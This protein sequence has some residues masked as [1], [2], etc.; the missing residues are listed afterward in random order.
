MASQ[1]VIID[2]PLPEALS[3][4]QLKA[5]GLGYIEALA[6]H[7]WSNLNTSDPGV[8]IL[9]QLCYAQTELG[10][11]AQFPIADV[12]TQADGK[13]AYHNQ[14]F[15]PQKILTSGP[16]TLGDYRKLAIDS[17]KAVNNL[18]LELEQEP[19]SKSEP[20]CNYQLTGGY[21]AFVYLANN[22]SSTAQARLLAD[23]QARLNQERNLAEVFRLPQ[24]LQPKE[25]YIHGCV[26]LTPNAQASQVYQSLIQ[27]LNQYVSPYTQQSGFQ[28]LRSAGLT[29]SEIFNGPEL[30]CGWMASGSRAIQEAKSHG[31]GEKRDWVRLSELTSLI[32]ACEGV[33][34][35]DALSIKS[36]TS[37]NKDGLQAREDIQIHAKYVANLQLAKDFKLVQDMQTQVIVRQDSSSYFADTQARHQAC[38]IQAEVDLY[39]KLPSGE[40]RDISDYYSVQNTMP[41]VYAIGANALDANASAY[42]IAQSRQLKGYLTLYDQLLA[43]QFSQLA[44]IGDLFSFTGQYNEGASWPLKSPH[45][46]YQRFTTTYYFQPLYQVPDIKPLLKGHLSYHYQFDGD[47]TQEQLEAKAWKQYRVDPFNQYIYG[48]RQAMESDRNALQR[49]NQMLNH[50]MARHGD[51]A[52]LYEDMIKTCQWFGSELKTLVMVKS[53]WLQNYQSLS[54]YRNRAYNFSEAN[55]LSLPGRYRL[56]QEHFNKL[57]ELMPD[58]ELLIHVKHLIGLANDNKS[59][60]FIAMARYLTRYASKEE[61]SHLLKRI[62]KLYQEAAHPEDARYLHLDSYFCL[63][64]RLLT[65][66]YLASNDGVLDQ[67]QIF[68]QAKLHSAD[69]DNFSAFEL[70]LNLLL[71]FAQRLMILASKLKELL[72][73]DS[74]VEW[75]VSGPKT[76]E[77][78]FFSESELMIVRGDGESLADRVHA[79]GELLLE[80]SGAKGKGATVR[81]YHK[82]VSQL[83]WLAEQRKGCILIEHMLL[84]YQDEKPA[85]TTSHGAPLI[86]DDF[87]FLQASMLFP[88]YVTLAQQAYFKH[89]LAS[90]VGLH[91]PAHI[92]LN[93]FTPSFDELSDFIAQFVVMHN[94]LA[95]EPGPNSSLAAHKIAASLF[96]WQKKSH[97]V[98]TQS[99]LV[100]DG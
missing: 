85:S 89:Y 17:F 3:Y 93:I 31:P 88:G 96:Q 5:K 64:E 87:Y 68:A 90:L 73:D 99:D 11:C 20:D 14:F 28:Q 36:E 24:A 82:H 62:D 58:N 98:S 86:P 70:K 94:E 59:N 83:L 40:Y 63:E 18:Y 72:D 54:Y 38:S 44:H 10:Y 19:E 60:L 2:N 26:Y 21:Q 15:E 27:A 57:I 46:H 69:F 56:T 1:T 13:I 79:G 51:D 92:R 12:L 66:R 78:Q 80:V 74:F 30:T 76:G 33:S 50:L 49:R 45:L 84:V 6:G 9:E 71:G 34:C 95:G 53:I 29:S 22:L 81:H 23:I 48:L 25:I 7:H 91:W 35:V 47:Q 4:S 41:S 67:H 75:I 39:P 97:G 42:R 8:T 32:A 16:I 77:R 52:S 43:N 65:E 55:L 100:G 61:V 37:A